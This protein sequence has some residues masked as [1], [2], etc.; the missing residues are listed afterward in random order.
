MSNH[1][2][3][4]RRRYGALPAVLL[5]ITAGVFAQ[6]GTLP[7]GTIQIPGGTGTWGSAPPSLPAGTRM[8]VLEGNPAAKGMFTMRLRAPAGARLQA[9]WHPEAER[10]TIL[11]GRARVGFGDVADE[12]SMATFGPGSFYVNPP[13]SHHYVWI[14]EETEMQLTGVGPWEV[15]MVAVR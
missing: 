4:R 1:W 7:P 3:A 14:V 10:V 6:T 13:R 2:L 11:S 15:H 5:A 9:H 12:A 8:M